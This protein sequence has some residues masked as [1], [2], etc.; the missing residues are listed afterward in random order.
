MRLS[1]GAGALGDAQLP[2]GRVGALSSV[3]MVRPRASALTSLAL[4]FLIHKM[5]G[6]AHGTS[7]NL[8][9]QGIWTGFRLPS[10]G[11][12]FHVQR[13]RPWPG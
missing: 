3:L 9:S 11:L 4:R 1:L 2:E 5:E 6:L 8:R 12:A 13:G 7:E 10:P